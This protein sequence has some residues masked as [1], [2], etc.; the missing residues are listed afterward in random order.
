MSEQVELIPVKTR[1]LTH[2]D[3]IVDVIQK[4]TKG[5]LGPDDVVSVAESVVAITQGRAVRP[6]DLKPGFWARLVSR[7][8]PSEGSIAS[9]HGMQALINEEGTMRVLIA[10]VCGSIGKIFGQNG[11]FYRMAGEQARL[12]DDVTGTMPPYDKYIVYG[13]HDPN[14]VAEAI[15]QATGCFGAAVADVDDLKRAAVLGVSKGLDPKVLEKMLLD[16]PF[17][18]ASQKTPIVIIRNYAKT[19]NSKA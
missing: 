10:V 17:G 3:D 14:G 6:E 16:N 1:I 12:I 18:N 15:R 8:F 5:N 19:V 11:V 13:P 7:L 4:Y 9:W 2:K